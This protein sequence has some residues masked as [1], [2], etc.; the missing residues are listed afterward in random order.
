VC[1]EVKNWWWRAQNKAN[2]YRVN[3][4]MRFE[5][6]EGKGGF[7]ENIRQKRG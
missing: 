4:Q 7:N 1:I 5:D 2:R 3:R 6:T